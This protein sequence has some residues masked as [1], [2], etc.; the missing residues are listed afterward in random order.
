MYGK[1]YRDL[2]SIA[3]AAVVFLLWAAAFMLLAEFCHVF[4]FARKD[5][6][7][8]AALPLTAIGAIVTGRWVAGR[9][10]RFMLARRTKFPGP[11]SPRF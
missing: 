9:V 8:A 4:Q 1:Q 5:W 2:P 10:Y 6:L 3:A 11:Y 7:C